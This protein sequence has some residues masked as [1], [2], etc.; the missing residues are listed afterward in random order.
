MIIYDDLE[1]GEL[2]TSAE[3]KERRA[4]MVQ[5][6]LYI[7]QQEIIELLRDESKLPA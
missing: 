4:L 5:M 7:S 2:H 6:W 1:T 3:E